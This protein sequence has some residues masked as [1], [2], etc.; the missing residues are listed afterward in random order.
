MTDV[1]EG[2][3]DYQLEKHSRLEQYY[4]ITNC[5]IYTQLAS[6]ITKLQNSNI[7]NEKAKSSTE[8]SIIII[9]ISVLNMSRLLKI[10]LKF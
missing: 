2:K 8:G 3:K 7:Y 6:I 5:L 10:N 1:K 9:H 4:E